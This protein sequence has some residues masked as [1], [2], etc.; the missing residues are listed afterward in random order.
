M[1]TLGF[2]RAH[3]GRRVRTNW[4]WL[5]L[6][7]ALAGVTHA[8]YA[9]AQKCLQGPSIALPSVC[10]VQLPSPAIS[11]TVPTDM[12]PGLGSPPFYLIQRAANIFSWQAFM[13]LQWPASKN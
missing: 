8:T 3:E 6:C 2:R 13:S 9:L 4:R 12:Q 11:C 7:V 10:G 5:A 1:L